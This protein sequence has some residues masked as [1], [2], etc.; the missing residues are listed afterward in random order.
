MKNS[1]KRELD[2]ELNLLPMISM[3]AVCTCFLLVTT[4]WVQI[5]S[6]SSAQAYGT[7]SDHDSES[8]LWIQ[9]SGD[10]LNL[11]VKQGPE[12]VLWS[13]AG[14]QEAAL[15]SA[16]KDLKG[17]FPQL[18]TGLVQPGAKTKYE[19]LIRVMDIARKND[20]RDLGVAPL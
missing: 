15:D 10:N 19:N 4:V 8:V 12:K 7:S 13:K 9:V 14:I 3:L 6:L 5:G 16:L 2:F 11:S 20:V 17:R 1:N 18:S